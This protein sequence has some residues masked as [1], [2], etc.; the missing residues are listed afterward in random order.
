MGLWL[1]LEAAVDPALYCKPTLSRARDHLSL[2]LSLSIYLSSF[3]PLS[4]P[5]PPSFPLPIP[6]LTSGLHTAIINIPTLSPSPSLPCISHILI[7]C[8]LLDQ[9]KTYMYQLCLSLHT[10]TYTTQTCTHNMQP[11]HVSGRQSTTCTC[12]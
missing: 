8:S 11:Y 9:S 2:S 5:L 12:M 3:P 4:S 1:E 10:H 6:S 7:T